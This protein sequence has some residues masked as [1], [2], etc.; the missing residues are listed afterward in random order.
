MHHAPPC[1][2]SSPGE[3]EPGSSRRGAASGCS[4]AFDAHFSQGRRP[5]LRAHFCAPKPWRAAAANALISHGITASTRTGRKHRGQTAPSTRRRG[6]L[7]FIERL[8]PPWD[9]VVSPRVFADARKHEVSLLTGK[10]AEI[11]GRGENHG[12][13]RN[14][15]RG[16]GQHT[17]SSSV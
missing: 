14:C 10:R 11:L 8:C 17:V 16:V 4:L 12:D 1:S 3:R 2:D 9:G 13:R 5:L 15:P 7:C 6:T